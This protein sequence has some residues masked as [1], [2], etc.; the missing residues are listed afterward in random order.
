MRLDSCN[1]Y[2]LRVLITICL[3]AVLE[4][5]KRPI[6]LPATSL[7]ALE[8]EVS[9]DESHIRANRSLSTIVVSGAVRGIEEVELDWWATDA[10]LRARPNGELLVRCVLYPRQVCLVFQCLS[11]LMQCNDHVERLPEYR[12]LSISFLHILEFTSLCTVPFLPV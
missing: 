6:H 7:L 12:I 8:Q 4:S 9:A 10:Q 5:N 1:P 11:G 2:I 3:I